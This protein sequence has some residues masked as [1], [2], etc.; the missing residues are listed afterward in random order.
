MNFEPSQADAWKYMLEANS[1]T[2]RVVQVMP[3]VEERMAP[4]SPAATTTEPFVARVL[5]LFVVPLVR[6]VKLRAG[7][8]TVIVCVS[9]ESPPRPSLTRRVRV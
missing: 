9:I 4:P 2:L 1:V 5:R 3:S 7:S 8:E 6:W